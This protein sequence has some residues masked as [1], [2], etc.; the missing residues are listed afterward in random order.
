MSAECNATPRGGLTQAA[1]D[2]RYLKLTGGTLSGFGTTAP[3]LIIN[4]PAGYSGNWLDLQ[5][6]GSSQAKFYSGFGAGAEL[7]LGSILL[8]N[9]RLYA[10]SAGAVT[11]ENPGLGT[12]A[13]I[14]NDGNKII[15]LQD[16][17]S[18]FR[19]YNVY[20]SSYTNFEYLGIDWQATANVCKV[21]TVAGGTG[22]LRGM[23]LGALAAN[24][25]GFF[26]ATPVVQPT[27]TGTTAGFT[28]GTGT[29][30]MSVSTYTGNIGTTAYTIGDIVNAL[31][32][33]GLM[34]M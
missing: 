20:D 17:P 8:P 19:A 16:N 27:T 15:A 1:A 30:A 9:T 18:A 2:A 6:N 24:P 32:K 4:A 28:Q 14:A 3:G 26:G 33:L 10:F 23:I 31:K 21:S 11:L 13:A 22:V 5:T 34:A 7:T 29:I 25:I 12:R